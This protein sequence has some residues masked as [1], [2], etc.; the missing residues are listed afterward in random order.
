[1]D[2]TH[3]PTSLRFLVPLR[4]ETRHTPVQ[5]E[6]PGLHK[7][8]LLLQM[9]FPPF[10]PSF[11]LIPLQCLPVSH[12]LQGSSLSLSPGT[13]TQESCK[14]HTYHRGNTGG[15]TH[16]HRGLYKWRPQRSHLKTC[17]SKWKCCAV[18]AACALATLSLLS[19][20]LPST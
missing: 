1:M 17:S 19:R 14:E 2:Q 6:L 11:S 10:C 4:T 9:L 3:S 7:R 15:A 13:V 18:L 5:F 20:L 8:L 12:R 16:S